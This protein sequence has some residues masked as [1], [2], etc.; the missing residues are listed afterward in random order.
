MLCDPPHKLQVVMLARQL[1][2]PACGETL[3]YASKC[4]HVPP[5]TRARGWARWSRQISRSHL[6]E[7][8]LI[9]A[10]T[11]ATV[12]PISAGHSPVRRRRRTDRITVY[13]LKMY[14]SRKGARFAPPHAKNL[15]PPKGNITSTSPRSKGAVLGMDCGL[16]VC[17]RRG[18]PCL[19]GRGGP[20]AV[21]N[22]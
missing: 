19:S 1:K 22:S 18:L 5:L 16:G 17:P 15:H 21:A 8:V 9:L 14:T 2:R 11:I 13:F 12:A 3:Q 10:A 20:L 4:L 6:R 7:K